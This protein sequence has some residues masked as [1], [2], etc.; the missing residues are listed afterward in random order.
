MNAVAFSPDG[1]RVA[2]A[3]DDGSARV[4]DAATGEPAGPARPHTAA[5][6]AVAFSPD[7]TRVATASGD[8]IGAVWDARHR[9]PQ[10]R[11]A[12]TTTAR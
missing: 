10:L 7:G 8:R 1:T 2:T 4:L 12:A 11:P 3:S 5:V 6:R 9:E